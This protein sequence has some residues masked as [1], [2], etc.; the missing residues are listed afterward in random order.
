MDVLTLMA[1]ISKIATEAPVLLPDALKLMADQ[2]QVF[3]DFSKLVKD[4][5]ATK[6]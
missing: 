2:Q 5:Q 1:F 3:A 4:F 6:A